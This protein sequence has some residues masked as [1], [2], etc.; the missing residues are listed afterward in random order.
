MRTR[1]TAT[2]EAYHHMVQRCL[3]SNRPEYHR[4][5]GRGITLCERWTPRPAPD[6][7]GYHN[8]LA[9]MGERPEGL[10][11]DRIDNDGPYAPGNCRWATRAEQT[12]NSSKAKLTWD[13]VREIRSRTGV[14]YKELAVEFGV[15]PEQVS[16]IVR[17]RCWIEQG[18][19]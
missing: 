11:L 5:G 10:T 3:D 6:G 8:F 7:T 15:T 2:H 19:Q 14:L 4:Y 12:Q 18:G 13:D 9:D 16:N 17:R 1:R